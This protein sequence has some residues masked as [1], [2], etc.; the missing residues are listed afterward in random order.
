MAGNY[1]VYNCGPDNNPKVIELFSALKAALQPA[2][3]NL[4]L[5][6]SSPAYTV[7]FKDISRAP[8]VR[9]ILQKVAI[10]TPVPPLSGHGIAAQTPTMFCTTGENQVAYI[11]AAGVRIDTYAFCMNHPRVSAYIW[12]GSAIT[13]LCPKFFENPVAP[14]RSPRACL[15]V[16]PDFNIFDHDTKGFSDYQLWILLHELVH[17]YTHAIGDGVRDNEP[18]ASALANYCLMIPARMAVNHAYSYVYFVAGESVNFFL[19]L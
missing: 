5:P 4:L 10:G 9:D 18:E 11:T 15:T 8:F 19:E 6:V 1:G 13:V 7:F 2:L 12:R 17:Y 3:T 14:V 16:D